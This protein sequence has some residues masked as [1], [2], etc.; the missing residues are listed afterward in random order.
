MHEIF[1]RLGYFIK[2][3]MYDSLKRLSI[4]V[5]GCKKIRNPYE[6]K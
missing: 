5:E 3:F 4:S 2:S 6:K 1:L